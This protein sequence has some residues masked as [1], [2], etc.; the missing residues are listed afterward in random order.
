M[1]GH[2]FNFL[3]ALVQSQP[4]GSDVNTRARVPG[5]PQVGDADRVA[6]LERL[7]SVLHRWLLPS[8]STGFGLAQP[9]PTLPNESDAQPNLDSHSS[10]SIRSLFSLPQSWRPTAS[11]SDSFKSDVKGLTLR[12]AE[13]SRSPRP[14]TARRRSSERLATKLRDNLRI[15]RVE[16]HS[17]G[18]LNF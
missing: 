9:G 13:R 14:R 12:R 2:L 5:P 3:T 11:E 10:S 8:S 18:S 4:N 16:K 6:S 7:C 15:V 17:W 1:E